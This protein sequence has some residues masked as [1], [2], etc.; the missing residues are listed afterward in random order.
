MFI[1]F[2]FPKVGDTVRMETV[3]T[4]APTPKVVWLHNGRTLKA[5]AGKIKMREGKEGA[6]TLILESVGIEMDG[7]YVVKAEN[8]VGYVQ[9][10]ANVCVQGAA[11]VVQTFL[12]LE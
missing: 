8:T 6:H 11:S 2:S 4:G 1:A 7:E 10:S 5:A 3:I 12:P 9:T